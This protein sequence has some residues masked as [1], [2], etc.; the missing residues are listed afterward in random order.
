VRAEFFW[1]VEAVGRVRRDRKAIVFR[2]V[3]TIDGIGGGSCRQL[4]KGRICC[5]VRP[6][7]T[8]T[9]ALPVAGAAQVR[10]TESPLPV[11]RMFVGAPDVGDRLGTDVLGDG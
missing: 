5:P 8:T 7:A 1:S 11:M 10:T 2:F 3:E 4:L 9:A 6:P